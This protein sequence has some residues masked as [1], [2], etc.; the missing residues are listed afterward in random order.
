MSESLKMETVLSLCALQQVWPLLSRSEAKSPDDS[1]IR[2]RIAELSAEAMLI[3][4]RGI[5]KKARTETLDIRPGQKSFYVT[6]PPIDTVVGI[7]ARINTDEPRV[8]TSAADL[9][10]AEDI[11]IGIDRAARGEVYI[12]GEL[13]EAVEALQIVYTGGLGTI[14]G[15]WG[16]DGVSANTGAGGIGVFASAVGSFITDGVTAGCKLKILNGLNSPTTWTVL[17]VQSETQLTITIPF[18][19]GSA[20]DQRFYVLDSN[21]AS[22]IHDWP[23]IA[24]AIAAQT[25]NDW[26]MRARQGIVSENVGGVGVTWV[27]P[28]GW[29]NR[30]LRLLERHRVR[31]Y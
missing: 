7:T 16:W 8:W 19:S 17:S 13:R 23:L 18:T 14:T 4:N 9:V 28:G 25:A 11:F 22:I 15:A 20:T 6:C 30:N 1:L 29:L 3:M 24:S 21:G 27:P 26:T 2:Q 10:D 12:E 31:R 5:V